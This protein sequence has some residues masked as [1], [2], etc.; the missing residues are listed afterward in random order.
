MKAGEVRAE[1]GGGSKA[2][3]C[4]LGTNQSVPGVSGLAWRAGG[5]YRRRESP[6]PRHGMEELFLFP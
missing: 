6:R 1:N 4:P 3:S 2:L 5:P